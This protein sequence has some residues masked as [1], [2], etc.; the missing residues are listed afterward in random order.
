[1]VKRTNSNDRDIVFSVCF[2]HSEFPFLHDSILTVVQT[3]IN[4]SIVCGLRQHF[5]IC[6][7][8]AIRHQLEVSDGQTRLT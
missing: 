7:Y 8:P 3:P 4:S 6:I 5:G 2:Q 1:M